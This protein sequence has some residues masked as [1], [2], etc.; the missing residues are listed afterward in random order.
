M[1]V[2]QM[3][4][5]NAGLSEA[6]KLTDNEGCRLSLMSRVVGPK[7]QAR[8]HRSDS[9]PTTARSAELSVKAPNIEL[10]GCMFKTKVSVQFL[11]VA[12]HSF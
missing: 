11:S 2:K 9:S 1:S 12:S 8:K 3:S 7:K 6:E 5:V 10:I 4:N